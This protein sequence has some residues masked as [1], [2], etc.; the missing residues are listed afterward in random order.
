M[1]KLTTLLVFLSLIC[2]LGYPT[3]A[4][5][6][7]KWLFVGQLRATGGRFT[8]TQNGV[9]DTYTYQTG[10]GGGWIIGN[11]STPSPTGLGTVAGA[12]YTFTWDATGTWI[13]VTPNC[14]QGEPDGRIMINP[15]NP[16]GGVVGMAGGA[17]IGT[18]PANEVGLASLIFAG[19][20]GDTATGAFS[21]SM[22]LQDGFAATYSTVAGDSY[23]NVFNALLPQLL[24]NNINAYI[25]GSALD[26]IQTIPNNGSPSGAVVAAWGDPG[27]AFS[28]SVS[29]IT[30]PEPSTVAFLLLSFGLGAVQQFRKKCR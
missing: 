28:F 30:I 13:Q 11:A 4:S 21:I 8:V 14:G 18:V 10:P 5:A 17:A 24:A 1:K 27:L 22:G 19:G 23:Q 25:S 3:P 20:Q 16:A 15:L 9:T 29:S 7:A 2:V 12:Q 26:I 6:K